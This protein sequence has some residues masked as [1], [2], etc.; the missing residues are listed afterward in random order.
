MEFTKYALGVT[1]DFKLGVKTVYFFLVHL[2]FTY[3][4]LV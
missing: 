1:K 2:L 3:K 4:Y